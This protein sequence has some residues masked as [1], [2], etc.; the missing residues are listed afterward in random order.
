ML[1]NIALNQISI[2]K[3]TQYFMSIRK[4]TISEKTNITFRK[5]CPQKFKKYGQHKT[6]LTSLS[7]SIRNGDNNTHRRQRAIVVV[8]VW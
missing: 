8:I 2:F 7:V 1:N 4:F 5:R 3:I 6:A